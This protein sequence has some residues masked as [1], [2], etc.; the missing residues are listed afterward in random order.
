MTLFEQPSDYCEMEG[1]RKSLLKRMETSPNAS[2]VFSIYKEKNKCYEFV[3]WSK[4]IQMDN[5]A[6][7]ISN[8]WK[9]QEDL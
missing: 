4:D 3:N 5:P 9:V 1:N 2:T 6:I 7:Y 8:Q